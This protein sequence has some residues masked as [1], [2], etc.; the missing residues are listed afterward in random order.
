M[1][2]INNLATKI[3]HDYCQSFAGDPNGQQSR[4]EFASQLADEL[5]NTG[6]AFIWEVSNLAGGVSE[7]HA[8]P[9]SQ[10]VPGTHADDH[11]PDGFYTIYHSDGAT[12][13]IDARH[14]KKLTLPILGG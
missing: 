1:S 13:T 4:E 14:I 2:D 10:V 12:T 7:R 9:T 8:I 3:A 6:A 11:Y 5:V